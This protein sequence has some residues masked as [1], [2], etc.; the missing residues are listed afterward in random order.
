[1]KVWGYV[2]IVNCNGIYKIGY[3]MDSVASRVSNIQ[4]SNP[5]KVRLVCS[6]PSQTAS[7]LERELHQRFRDRRVRGEWYQL[8]RRQVEALQYDARVAQHEH[9]K[10][11]QQDHGSWTS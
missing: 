2:Y 3:T 5:N 7:T 4:M 8:T 6:I 11:A 10:W 1:M 9:F